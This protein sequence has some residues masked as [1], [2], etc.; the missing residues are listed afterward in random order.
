M[1]RPGGA[2]NTPGPDNAYRS[3]AVH[4]LL[5]ILA[6]LVRLLRPS[7]GLHA[8]PRV[9][10]REV[11]E[12]ARAARVRRYANPRPA[13]PTGSGYAFAL[14]APRRPLDATPPVTLHSVQ[15]E[16]VSGPEDLVRGYYLAHEAQQRHTRVDRDRSGVA[17]LR[18]NAVLEG[19]A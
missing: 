4:T 15:A 19:V 11:R 2:T 12:E 9:L 13:R 5:A 1:K 7:H 14:P 18:E 3:V 8:A 6:T 17:V 16:A 10:R